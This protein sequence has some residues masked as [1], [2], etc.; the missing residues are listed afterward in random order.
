MAVSKVKIAS[1]IGVT[2]KLDDVIRLCGQTQYFHPDDAL[3]F[4]S[5]TRKFTTFT[6]ANPYSDILQELKSLLIRIGKDLDV[7][8][9]RRLDLPHYELKNY[10]ERFS[11]RM[12][13]LL[14]Q[15]EALEELQESYVKQT[16]EIGHFVGLNLDLKKLA[17]CKYIKF[18]FGRIP[19][20]C[21]EKLSKYEDN[22][23]VLFFQ[24]TSDAT[25]YWGVYIA[26]VEYIQQVDTIFF[27]T[28]TFYG[29]W[30]VLT[31]TVTWGDDDTI[32][33]A[34]PGIS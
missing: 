20:E 15:K 32:S 23:Y 31:G 27:G 5:D 3:S 7:V 14:N 22:P 21:Y 13:K 8:D 17:E 16:V 33:S 26:P 19:K 6:D 1:I 12:D 28:Q 2:D 25:H 34:S 11:G 29:D 24:C 30:Q 18:R 9:T 10:V 4:Y